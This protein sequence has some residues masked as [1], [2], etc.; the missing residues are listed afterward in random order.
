MTKLYKCD[1]CKKFVSKQSFTKLSEPSVFRFGKKKH[2]CE[3]CAKSF[4]KWFQE[5]IK[6]NNEER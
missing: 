5:G 4:R 3:E 6:K 2:L 1:R